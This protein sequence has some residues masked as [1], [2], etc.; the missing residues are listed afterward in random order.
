MPPGTVYTAGADDEG[1]V[2]L[3]RLEVTVTAGTGK[4]RTPA[5]LE[6]GLKESLNRAWSYLQSVRDRMGLTPS[7]AQKDIVAEAMDLT[8]GR[9][10]CACGMCI[11]RGHAVR[12]RAATRAGRDCRPG[13]PDYSRQH[14]SPALDHRGA[15]ARPENGALRVLLPTGNKSQ[16]SSLPEDV[17]EK[18]DIVFYSEVDRAVAKVVEV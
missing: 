5:G 13:R 14:Q 16:F 1:R 2:A 6:H 8:G 9:V 11:P 7:L 12:C 4:L 10:E 15:P 17:V 3:Y 18:L